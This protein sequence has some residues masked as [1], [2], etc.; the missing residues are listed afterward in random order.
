V[1]LVGAPIS[2]RVVEHTV[3]YLSHLKSSKFTFLHIIP[4]VPPIYWDHTRIFDK[5]E[6]KALEVSK[7]QWMQEYADLVN[8]I[9][10]AGQEKLRQAGIRNENVTFKVLPARRG[11]AGDI[12]TELESGRYGVMVIGRKGSKELSPFRL[13]SIANKLLHNAQ[14]CMICLVN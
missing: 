5:L 12:L 2:R 11:M 6:R 8:E 4:P 7:A 9:A 3:K 13:G 10:Q 1:T 14:N